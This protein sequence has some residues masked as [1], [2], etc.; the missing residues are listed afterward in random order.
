MISPFVVAVALAAFPIMSL[1]D[2]PNPADY[3]KPDT[4]VPANPAWLG[5]ALQGVPSLP[6]GTKPLA[7]PD[8]PLTD[9]LLG[10]LAK[11]SVKATFF[12]VGSRVIEY[13]DVLTRT[14]QAGHQIGEF[15][16]EC[17]SVFTWS[18]PYLSNTPSDQIVAEI[19]YTAKAI[20]QVIGVTPRFMRAPYGDVDERVRAILKNLGMVIVA[21]NIDSGDAGGATDVANQFKT[22]ANAG[23][24]GYISLEHDLFPKTEPQ[25]APALDAILAG[26]G[27]YKPMPVAVCLGQ[28]AY[29]EGL[30][31]KVGVA[32]PS[33]G[34]TTGSTNT[35]ASKSA[36]AIADPARTGTASPGSKS[37]S[38]GSAVGKPSSNVT[39]SSASTTGSANLST[40]TARPADKPTLSSATPA[41]GLLLSFSAV[42]LCS[43]SAFFL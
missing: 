19:V 7:A 35:T 31:A 30:W 33:G 2:K 5:T 29:D 17:H 6:V 43:I 23:G 41:T 25:A 27:G 28:Q 37:T 9:D 20:K 18:H 32:A 38:L 26:S 10:E 1:A 11:R 16:I 15:P 14:Y 22:K 4:L 36:G 40:A 3:P 8:C 42:A 34:I 39:L 24:S 12:V 13:P 21:W